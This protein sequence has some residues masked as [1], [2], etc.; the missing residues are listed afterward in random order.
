MACLSNEYLT[1]KREETSNRSRSN[2]P[3]F[4]ALIYSSA[5]DLTAL[6]L[7]TKSGVDKLPVLSLSAA[8]A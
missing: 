7:A 8:E 5:T 1:D 6:L 4:N 3:M 2:S